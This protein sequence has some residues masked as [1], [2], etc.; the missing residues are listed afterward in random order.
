MVRARP[1]LGTF[2]EIAADGD[3]SH[4]TSAV[5]QAFRAIAQVHRL[6]SFQEPASDVSRINRS[7]YQRSVR[8]HPWTWRVLERA[9]ALYRVTGGVFDCASHR[10]GTFGDVVLEAG[11]RVRFNRPL[12]LDLSGIAKGFAVDQAV[13]V[14]K[15]GGVASGVVN[16]GGD[17]RVFGS[18]QRVHVR[19]PRNGSVSG[20]VGELHDAAIATSARERIVDPR[21]ARSSVGPATITVIAPTCMI[22]DAFT[23]VVAI[24]GSNCGLSRWRAQAILV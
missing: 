24:L 8:V 12:M 17:L 13:R 6:M 1:L 21:Q 16:A 14:L 20:I 7:A 9:R 3:A 11:A 4:V 19:D 10:G 23:K 5:E 22:A 18:P 15:R 2:V